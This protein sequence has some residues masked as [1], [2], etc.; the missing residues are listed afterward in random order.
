MC[1]RQ[2]YRRVSSLHRP[3]ADSAAPFTRPSGFLLFRR[4]RSARS[5]SHRSDRSCGSPDGRNVSPS[6]PTAPIR[7]AASV[8]WKRLTV[9]VSVREVDQPPADLPDK[10]R[11]Y[12]ESTQLG[13]QLALIMSLPR[14]R[15]GV[16]SRFRRAFFPGRC[17]TLPTRSP[18]PTAPLV[19]WPIANF[20]VIRACCVIPRKRRTRLT[21]E[22]CFYFRNW[23]GRPASGD[24]WNWRA[25]RNSLPTRP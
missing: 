18:P 25:I 3:P 19:I 7:P 14:G 8:C 15:S 5:K 10:F 11:D 12:L 1:R 13:K 22:S 21:S 20:P 23:T 9:R 2:I 4:K 24:F 16:V 17:R 6:F